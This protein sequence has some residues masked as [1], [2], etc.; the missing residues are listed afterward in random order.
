MPTPKRSKA[1][2][3]TTRPNKSTPRSREDPAGA[4]REGDD[5]LPSTFTDRPTA[6]KSLATEEQQEAFCLAVVE[7]AGIKPAC[8]AAYGGM[9]PA[10]VFYWASKHKDFRDL[11][12]SALAAVYEVQVNETF[13]LTADLLKMK[14]VEMNLCA[15]AYRVAVE[16]RIRLLGKLSPIYTDKMLGGGTTSVH[17]TNNALI[18]DEETRQRLIALRDQIVQQKPAIEAVVVG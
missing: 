10:G 17:V 15:N 9:N 16:Q 8:E 4:E 6:A 5:R 11:L 13:Q 2:S 1:R 14:P 7:H 18:V 12:N 3:S